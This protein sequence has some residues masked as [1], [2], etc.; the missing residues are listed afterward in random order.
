MGDNFEFLMQLRLDSAAAVK[1]LVAIMERFKK[2]AA[3]GVPVKIDPEMDIS[4]VKERV[5]QLATEIKTVAKEIEKAEGEMANFGKTA[6]Q[7][8]DKFGKAMPKMSKA[9]VDAFGKGDEA[10]KQTFEKILHHIDDF[11]KKASAKDPLATFNSLTGNQNKAVAKLL[12]QMKQDAA[13]LRKARQ[14]VAKAQDD[15]A[16]AA[17]QRRV[18]N[19]QRIR[20]ENLT[21]LKGLVG[22]SNVGATY[23]SFF[24]TAGGGSPRGA[25]VAAEAER[26]MR[27]LFRRLSFTQTGTSTGPLRGQAGGLVGEMQALLP[28]TNRRVVD[29]RFLAE[30]ATARHAGRGRDIEGFL[31]RPDIAPHVTPELRGALNRIMAFY[32]SSG[33]RA[34]NG[35]DPSMVRDFF[36]GFEKT[37]APNRSKELMRSFGNSFIS[38][39]L[40]SLENRTKKVRDRL[41]LPG[42]D[43]AAQPSFR[44]AWAQR[45]ATLMQQAGHFGARVPDL[46]GDKL[47]NHFNDQIGA[48]TAY[49]RSVRH[50]EQSSLD[51]ANSDTM[52]SQAEAHRRLVRAQTGLRSNQQYLATSILAGGSGR[53]QQYLSLGR[54]FEQHFGGAL[55]DYNRGRSVK[56][57]VGMQSFLRDVFTGSGTQDTTKAFLRSKGIS[58]ELLGDEKTL[59]TELEKQLAPLREAY[60]IY[61][62]IEHEVAS[63]VKLLARSKDEIA[64]T[65]ANAKF[66]RQRGVL[67]ATA[68][69]QNASLDRRMGV[70]QVSAHAYDSTR[71]RQLGVREALAYAMEEARIRK[72]GLQE[73][74]AAMD[75]EARTRKSGV[76]ESVAAAE[77]VARQARAQRQ[78]MSMSG[79]VGRAQNENLLYSLYG[80]ADKTQLRRSYGNRVLDPEIAHTMALQGI[81]A[82]GAPAPK[83]GSSAGFMDTLRNGFAMFGGIGLGYTAANA[84]RNQ[85]H[86]LLELEQVQKDIQGILQSRNSGDAQNVMKGVF[87]TAQK[88]GSDLMQT[89]EAAKVLAQTGLSASEVMKE[90]DKTLSAARGMGMAIE[91]VQELQVAVHAVTAENDRYNQSISYTSAV[92]DKIAVVEAKYAVRSTDLAES[93]KL[94]TP[95]IDNFTTGMAHLGDSFDYTIGL[96][97]VMVDKLRITGSQAANVLK[98]VF[99]RIARPEILKKLQKDFQLQLGNSETG[100]YLPLDT[101]INTLGEKYNSLGG[102]GQ[103]KFAT[104][105]SGGRN[106]HAVTALLESYTQVAQ[107]AAEASD[108]FGDANDRASISMDTLQATVNKAKTSFT[109]FLKN[110]ADQSYIGAGV[111]QIFSFLGGGFQFAAEGASGGLIGTLLTVLAGGAL[112][113]G[114]QKLYTLAD[115]ARKAEGSARGLGSILASI[116]TPG[117][118]ILAGTAAVVGTIGFIADQ[119]RRAKEEAERYY[120]TARNIKDIQDSPQYIKFKQAAG[121]LSLG[122]PESAH[123]TVKDIVNGTGRQ[124]F[125]YLNEVLRQFSSMTDT[126]FAQWVK[127]HPKLLYKFRDD[128]VKIFQGDLPKASHDLFAAM[129]TD[130]Q[131]IS[132]VLDLVGGSAFSA[133]AIMQKAIQDINDSTQRMVDD[134][135]AGLKKIEDAKNNPSVFYQI[136]GAKNNVFDKL[137]SQQIGQYP[138]A[139]PTLD[140]RKLGFTNLR[141]QLNE[142]PLARILLSDKSIEQYATK[143]LFNESTKRA[144]V[145][146][147]GPSYINLFNTLLELLRSDPQMQ[148][149]VVAAQLRATGNLDKLAGSDLFVNGQGLSKDDQELV[150]L[151]TSAGLLQ[152]SASGAAKNYLQ[153]KN[154]GGTRLSTA[155]RLLRMAGSGGKGEFVE[156]GLAGT[157]LA[158]VTFRDALL[159]LTSTIYESIHKLNTESR[160]AQKFGLSYDRNGAL[161][162]LGRQILGQGD[163]FRTKGTLDLLKIRREAEEAKDVLTKTDGL[164]DRPSVIKRRK[165]DEQIKLLSDDLA[166]FGSGTIA[167]IFGNSSEGHRALEDFRKE[168][169]ASTGDAQVQLGS[170]EKLLEVLGGLYIK[171]GQDGEDTEKRKQIALE[172]QTA[173]LGKQAELAQA[174][175]PITARAAEQEQIR[176]AFAAEQY[177]LDR[178]NL[179][180]RRGNILYDQQENDRAIDRLD[181]TYKI[182]ELYQ[183]QLEYLKA[184]N[185]LDQQGKQNL[186]GIL[187]GFKSTLTDQSIWEGIFNPQGQ[188]VEERAR[189]KA[190]AIRN[191]FF[192]TFSPVFKTITDRFAENLLSAVSDAL[193]ELSGVQD[194][195]K[196][197]EGR[198]KG[199]LAA[200]KVNYDYATQAGN[201]VGSAWFNSITSAGQAVAAEWARVLG[202]PYS[203][204]AMG[205]APGVT[206]L[207]SDAN[208]KKVEDQLRG[209]RK[210]ALISGAGMMVGTV[211]GTILGRGGRGAQL[212]ANVGS[213]GGMIV[214]NLIGG[215]IGGAV[216]SAIGG[217]VGGLFG[218]RTDKHDQEIQPIVKGLEAI[219]RAQRDTITTIT[220]QTDALLKPENRFLNLPSN[221]AIPNRAPNF[222]GSVTINIDARGMSKDDVQGAVEEAMSTTLGME[223]RNRSRT[224]GRAA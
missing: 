53:D 75:D 79:L 216:G 165:A 64:A 122:S 208:A 217:L 154:E 110:V 172:I 85:V 186:D 14:D 29:R 204:G 129:E 17:A 78:G 199:D 168:I 212:G 210:Q 187:S 55:N 106:V 151:Q 69:A 4:Q 74:K 163:D 147:N 102:Y 162:S 82:P 200:A 40:T 214:G 76:L 139:D 203:P 182:N 19:F 160:I 128:F 179:V 71:T 113:R 66:V 157:N 58:E 27:A 51:F 153:N 190:E 2:E 146:G 11:K 9:L 180:D 206:G 213:V 105:L 101:L 104:E 193:F 161:I 13:D 111:K 155:A 48:Y 41:A 144:I 159:N 136:F 37:G 185:A 91:Q 61:A 170:L 221:F 25:Q 119:Y 57:Q 88:Y 131:R 115:A 124:S 107:I 202:V 114:T 3:K 123:G 166:D 215:P 195:V 6:Q 8:T 209:Y 36:N 92:L 133:A 12:L 188:S 149:R 117:G 181:T 83:R 223:R 73:V 20:Q 121:D 197:P 167:A 38:E 35:G 150:R 130:G 135:V 65:A 39:Y 141:A 201:A 30:K 126:Q 145:G 219:E 15:Y 222:G 90:L 56:D 109:L 80:T 67:E 84:I 54:Q 23:R 184:R 97:T 46:G 5:K 152:Q 10:A 132:G 224:P 148:K 158:L 143:N 42:V 86:Q 156:T 7:A 205:S 44:E 183:S 28:L 127:D 134:T 49:Q 31:G 220:A 194:F 68:F 112:T 142:L 52:E 70:L 191:V 175:L 137:T 192:N 177:K 96:T 1:D 22:G 24:G 59:T 60:Q 173:Q 32:D 116:F 171:I 72:G 100:D 26:R 174:L 207:P 178:Q 138:G 21:D 16:R 89:A 45:Y 99:S 34:I 87:A 218:G 164:H 118:V 77:D 103:K 47:R 169:A 18:S 140:W 211:G 98:M 198:L 95:L 120:V 33:R 94:L 189:N 81:G 196:S 176:Q 43:A 50:Y 93:I 108:S 63:T 62:D 125:G